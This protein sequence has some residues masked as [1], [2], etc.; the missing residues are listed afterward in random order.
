MSL[1]RFT[2]DFLV[3]LYNTVLAP[4]AVVVDLFIIPVFSK[5]AKIYFYYLKE[6][7]KTIKNTTIIFIEFLIE[8]LPKKKW[9]MAKQSVDETGAKKT[10]GRKL[11]QAI[12]GCPFCYVFFM[13]KSIL[14]K[15]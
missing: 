8:T 7:H 3:H 9:I 15:Q 12:S 11:K 13:T 2:P 6:K 5:I 10:S 1:S 14:A 4:Q